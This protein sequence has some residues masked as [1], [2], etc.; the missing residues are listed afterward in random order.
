M[1]EERRVVVGQF[2]TQPAKPPRQMPAHHAKRRDESDVAVGKAADGDHRTGA[3]AFTDVPLPGRQPVERLEGGAV[4]GA[5]E[6]PPFGFD[7]AELAEKLDGDVRRDDACSLA[8]RC[9]RGGADV[10]AHIWSGHVL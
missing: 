4:G 7:R 8:R 1:G 9:G 3:A 10:D 5:L 6:L 2:L